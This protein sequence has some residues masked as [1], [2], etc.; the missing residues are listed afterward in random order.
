MDLSA[1]YS[2]YESCFGHHSPTD[3]ERDFRADIGV[4]PESLETIYQKYCLDS[5][6][7][8]RKRLM[9]D[10]NYLKVYPTESTVYKRFD[11]R[12]RTTYRH[13]L[14]ETLRYLDEV[15]DEI[16]I[17]NRFYGRVATQGIFEGIALV[18]DG[19]DIPIER[20][21]KKNE[22]TGVQKWRRKLF[23]SGRSKEN[24]RSKYCV[25]FTVGVQIS[26]G[27][28]CFVDGPGPGS[29]ND[30]TALRE[31]GLLQT[32]R[33]DDIEEVIL[34]DKGFSPVFLSFFSFFRVSFF[35]L[36]SLTFIF[37]LFCFF[38]LNFRFLTVNRLCR[39][40]GSQYFNAN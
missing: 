32:I 5:P 40:K 17:E 29:M 8:T 38:H 16:R 10:M 30:L 7:G 24:S 9:M 33:Q 31:S 1:W 18:V 12:T 11:Y 14:W 23:Y 25:K 36:S 27:R 3:N 2:L 35:H 34:A 39:S 6:F 15:M 21:N 28:I 4:H 22:D 26:T 19:T 37:L 13:H 20:P